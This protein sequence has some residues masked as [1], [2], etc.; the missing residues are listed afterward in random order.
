MILLSTT[1]TKNVHTTIP[2]NVWLIGV[3]KSIN[4]SQALQL[5][6]TALAGVGDELRT[7]EERREAA[8]AETLAIDAKIKEIKEKQ[9]KK[10]HEAILDGGIELVPKMD[11]IKEVIQQIRERRRKNEAAKNE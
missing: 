2:Y 6:I 9:A 10:R 8:I 5:G 7:L 1:T 3:H 4:W 11:P